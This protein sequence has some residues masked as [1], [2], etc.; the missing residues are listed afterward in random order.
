MYRRRKLERMAQRF[1]QMEDGK[2]KLD[3]AIALARILV[4]QGIHDDG[5]PGSGNHGTK[6]CQAKSVAPLLVEIKLY[7]KVASGRGA[8]ISRSLEMFVICT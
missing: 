5:G 1:L 2:E 8:E 7:P 3:L 4:S 6:E